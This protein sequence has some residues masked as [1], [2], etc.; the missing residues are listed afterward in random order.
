MARK[1]EIKPRPT[2]M[3][4]EA[5]ERHC[6]EAAYALAQKQLDD[7]TA[8]PSVIT[9]FLKLATE[10]TKLEREKLARQNELLKTKNDSYQDSKKIEELYAGAIA[11]MRTYSGAGDGTDE[12]TLDD[13]FDE[14]W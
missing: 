11:A 7:G 12:G 13:V 4:P 8:S 2:P 9:H 5:A 10:D 1:Q 6:I 14:D 3:T